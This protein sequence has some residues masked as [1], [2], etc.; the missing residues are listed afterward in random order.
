MKKKVKT[1]MEKLK[2]YGKESVKGISPKIPRTI[3][4]FL[5]GNR[6]KVKLGWYFVLYLRRVEKIKWIVK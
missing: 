5:L 2:S 1:T 4:K 3:N 6:M